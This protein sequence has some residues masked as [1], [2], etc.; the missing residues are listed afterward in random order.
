MKNKKYHTVAVP[1][2]IK[3]IV[4]K[5]HDCLIPG[6]VSIQDWGHSINS[7]FVGGGIP[8]SIRKIVERSKIDTSNTYILSWVGMYTGTSIISMGAGGCRLVLWA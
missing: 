3:K 4:G 7:V 1:K 5:R 2:S 8:K 6:L